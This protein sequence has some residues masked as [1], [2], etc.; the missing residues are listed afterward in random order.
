MA[1]NIVLTT[2]EDIVA[3]VDAIVAKGH[4]VDKNFVTEFTGIATD[5]QV[6]KALEMAME[7]GMASFDAS[8]NCYSVDSFLAKKLV[9]ATSDNQKAVI[10]RLILEQYQPYRIFK[11]RYGF[12]KSIEQACK[13]TKILCSLS[14]NE[15]DIKNTLISIAT[16]AKAL[17]SEGANLYSFVEEENIYPL[18]ET[19][20][21]E[22]AV[23]EKSLRDFWGETIYNTVDN[24]TIV[25]PLSEAFQKS[26]AQTPDMRAVI[27]Y[28]ANA[29][30]SF[31]DRYATSHSVSLSGKNGILQKR[32]ALSSCLSKKHRGMIDYIGQ[33]RNA[34]DHGADSDEGGQMWTIT[35]DTM[36][37]YPCVVAIT[38]KNI[39]QRDN[40]TIEV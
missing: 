2:A 21:L 17:K 13:Q 22:S 11:V 23:S 28:A 34:A 8:S 1:Y 14:S 5:D 12:T 24:T 9:T 16:Y 36:L 27:V 35:K 30:E 10:M 32:D 26:K 40:G 6:N 33:I 31:L 38:I 19:N 39:L 25:E 3:V 4:D 15:R 20:L 18:V 29:F 37:L 7:L